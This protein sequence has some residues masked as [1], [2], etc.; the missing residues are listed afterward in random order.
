MK[1]IAFLTVF[2]TFLLLN[3]CQLVG[4]S[5]SDIVNDPTKYDGKTVTVSGEVS[6]SANL[7]L[8]KTYTITDGKKEIVVT[9]KRA[10]PKKGE[11]VTVTGKVSQLLKVGDA[12]V[13][14]IEEE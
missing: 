8:I 4:P 13:V 3:A 5:I 11:N 14:G 12:Q 2:A 1:K 6:N 7:I 9:T 10:V